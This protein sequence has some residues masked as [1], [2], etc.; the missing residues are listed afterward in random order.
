MQSASNQ[1][2]HVVVVGAG[3]AGVAAA[4]AL[5][6][7]GVAVTLL[8]QS[9][10][11]GGRVAS[12]ADTLSDGTP[13]HMERG[14]HAFFRHYEN[15]RS[16]L[17]RVDPGLTCL[18]PLVDYPLLAPDGRMQ[19]FTGLPKTPPFNVMA[20]LLRSPHIRLRD[21]ANADLHRARSLL[22]FDQDT[23]YA[24]LDQ[25]SAAAFLD[26]L[27]FPPRARQMLFDVFAH[28]FFNPEASYSAAELLAMFHFYFTGNAAGLLFDVAN[29][30]FD[31]A[32]WA[33]LEKCLRG[34]GA[35]VEK[36]A[37]CEAITRGHERDSFTVKYLQS[38]ERHTV[39]ATDVVL[40]VTVPAVKQIAA[41]SPCLAPIA[42]GIDSLDV[43]Q[44]F[45]V[46]RLW[47]DKPCAPGRPPFA[48]TTGFGL[49]DNISLYE[50]LEDESAQWARAHGGSVV[51]LH[52][53]AIADDISDAR[54]REQLLAD[55]RVAYPET[56]G[57][58]VVDE[59][60]LVRR[61]CPAFRPGSFALRPAVKSGIERLSFAGD[62][63]RLPFP[64]AL[65]ERAVASGFLA[66][67]ETLARL[68]LPLV[69][70]AHG[71]TRGLLAGLDRLLR[72]KQAGPKRGDPTVG[73]VAT[74]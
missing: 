48:G 1:A 2:P 36:G 69:T 23:T 33:P 66:A 54:T 39:A 34:H 49:C 9:A 27:R 67:N 30:P 72:G 53:Y 6:E 13:F 65:M 47:L 15:V 52:A 44:R 57:A 3:L 74:R 31:S 38:G 63:V 20:L 59:R 10:V 21:L 58:R 17:R 28:S 41:A 22:A 26:E 45:A 11:L 71:T 55:L 5:A 4:V 7:R 18:T 37:A 61:D 42:S 46:L 51:E 19:S 32:I 24:D 8:E 50:K 64:S 68:G 35:R 25:M 70:V 16:L 43:T 14:F 29:K 56:A 62:F 73:G 60:Y 12:W 40:A